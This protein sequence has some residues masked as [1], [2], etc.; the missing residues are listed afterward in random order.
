M[1]AIRSYYAI[2]SERHS[3]RG[4]KVLMFRDVSDVEKA[5]SEVRKSEKLLR[6]LIDSYNFV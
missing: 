3:V 5:Q 6:T 2:N 1:Y 4:G